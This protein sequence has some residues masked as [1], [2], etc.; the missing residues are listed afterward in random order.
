M[1]LKLNRRFL[2]LSSSQGCFPR[3]WMSQGDF[4][5]KAHDG[6]E[7]EAAKAEAEE[8]ALAKA[9]FVDGGGR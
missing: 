2:P 4:L 5:G 9:D 1:R 3:F 6:W 7:L 8:D